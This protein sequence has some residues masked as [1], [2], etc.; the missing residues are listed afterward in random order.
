MT[1]LIGGDSADSHGYD[2]EEV[3]QTRV[4]NDR[5]ASDQLNEISKARTQNDFF[6]L[7]NN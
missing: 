7:R 5:R 4:N 3:H 1:A 2:M 6:W